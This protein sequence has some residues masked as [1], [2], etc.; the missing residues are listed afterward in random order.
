MLD[1]Y[2]EDFYHEDLISN[3]YKFNIPDKI[4]P[5]ELDIFEETYTAYILKDPYI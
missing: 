5:N 2:H 4:N 1:D 3:F